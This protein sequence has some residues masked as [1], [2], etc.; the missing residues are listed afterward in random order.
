MLYSVL[1]FYRESGIL[2][3]TDQTKGRCEEVEIR[4]M[5]KAGG[6][7]D[8]HGDPN[9]A[10]PCNLFHKHRF[11]NHSRSVNIYISKA[12]TLGYTNKT[13]YLL[14]AIRVIC[15]AVV[16]HHTRRQNPKLGLGTSE[17]HR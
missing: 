15:Y 13:A 8:L 4:S 5:S 11:K 7:L 14:R 1:F 10:L 3:V 9:A 17:E 16:D 6:R 12:F 2:V